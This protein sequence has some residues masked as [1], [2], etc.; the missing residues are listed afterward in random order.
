MFFDNSAQTREKW[1]MCKWYKVNLR[2]HCGNVKG[3][4]AFTNDNS[5]ENDDI[6]NEVYNDF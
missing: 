6:T 5:T 1:T 2:Y 4:L 3:V